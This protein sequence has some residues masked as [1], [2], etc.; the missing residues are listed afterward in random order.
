MPAELTALTLGL[1]RML[2]LQ[3]VLFSAG[4]VVI[5]LCTQPARRIVLARAVLLGSL[6][7]VPV[8][9]AGWGP[10]WSLAWST[11]AWASTPTSAWY[12]PTSARASGWFLS[13]YAAL[14]GALAGWTF[15]GLWA[16]RRVRARAQPACA[17]VLA[18]YR[19]IAEPCP[20]PPELRVSPHAKRPMLLGAV[21]PVILIPPSLDLPE[22]IQEARLTLL[23]EI[24]HS[25]RADVASALLAGLVQA[26]WPMLPMVWWIR[27]QMLLDQELLADRAAAERF[28]GPAPYASSLVQFASQADSAGTALKAVQSARTP[29]MLRVLM[30][31]KHAGPVELKVPAWWKAAATVAVGLGVWA[32]SG[33]TLP[34]P[35]GL[36]SPK[37]SNPTHGTFQL[38]RLVVKP[39]PASSDGRVRPYRVCRLPRSYRVSVD[40][41]ADPADLGRMEVAGFPLPQAPPSGLESFHRVEVERNRQDCR[42]WVDG[43]PVPPQTP[44]P[45]SPG[46]WLEL[47]PAPGKPGRYRDLVLRW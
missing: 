41:W 45:L 24:E 19:R 37:L 30:L 13:A 26:G 29:L 43:Q 28:G 34:Q 47:R 44:S 38:S 46:G 11:S 9:I 40:V 3:A 16:A 1:L 27:A 25:R 4:A 36:N 15:L 35:P 14:A 5:A 8:V 21:R 23:H 42:L 10:R 17:P 39:A 2:A 12:W 32:I 22:R 7:M 6:A 31:L 33:A 20:A 18:V